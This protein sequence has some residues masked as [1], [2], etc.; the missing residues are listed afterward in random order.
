MRS[1]YINNKNL[2]GK[3]QQIEERK[4]NSKKAEFLLMFLLAGKGQVKGVGKFE[5]KTYSFI[6][7]SFLS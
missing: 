5:K 2:D 7:S 6:S 1:S 3:K 4:N